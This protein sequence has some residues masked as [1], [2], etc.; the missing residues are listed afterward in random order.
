[1]NGEKAAYMT[2]VFKEKRERTLD[3]LIKGLEKEYEAIMVRTS[4]PV[5]SFFICLSS[6]TVKVPRHSGFIS[7]GL[8]VLSPR[9]QRR[10]NQAKVTEFQQIGQDLK[11]KRIVKGDAPT[12]LQTSTSIKRDVSA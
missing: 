2:P 9:V 3:V 10:K 7:D 5:I 12:S 1:M 8:P 4:R 6:F 11:L